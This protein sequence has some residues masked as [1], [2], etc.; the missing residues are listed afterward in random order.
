MKDEEVAN[1]YDI[2]DVM[3]NECEK[4]EYVVIDTLPGPLMNICQWCGHI[5]DEPWVCTCM[6]CGEEILVNN[7][8]YHIE[9]CQKH[10]KNG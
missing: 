6:D 9:I 3:Q 10:E 8:K 7:F 5:G 1:I 4:H 2:Y